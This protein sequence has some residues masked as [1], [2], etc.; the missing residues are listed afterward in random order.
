MQRAAPDRPLGQVEADHDV[1]PSRRTCCPGR[2]AWTPAV[3]TTSPASM[4]WATTTRG[5]V[6]A[7]PRS[8]L[9]SATVCVAGSTTQ[10]AGLSVRLASAPWPEPRC[11]ARRRSPRPV[12]PRSSRAAWRRADPI[13][14]TLTSIGAG[15]RVGLR[16]DLPHPSGGLDAG[17]VR[18]RDGRWSAWRGPMRTSCAGTS[19][20]ASRPSWRAT[21]YDHLPGLDHLA[22]L[23]A[24][25]RSSVPGAS[26]WS[27]V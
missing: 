26:A 25:W 4:P 18:Q 13:S 16:R 6:V 23:G 8:M 9:R 12:R 20:T 22:G 21:W 24:A 1:T 19:K 17:I 27:S 5:R 15:D 2:S 14:P 7:R 10:T 11:T 3:T